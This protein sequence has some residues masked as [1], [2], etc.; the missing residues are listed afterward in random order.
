MEIIKSNTEF[1]KKYG[2]F[3][4][5]E[6]C[7]FIYQDLATAK[8][9]KIIGGYKI[10]NTKKRVKFYRKGKDSVSVDFALVFTLGANKL[11]KYID[12]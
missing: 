11:N 12:N 5:R 10:N 9:N 6:M 2:K 3:E 1:I 8:A 7:K 4:F